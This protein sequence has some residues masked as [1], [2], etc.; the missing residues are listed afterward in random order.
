MS[1]LIKGELL[2]LYVYDGAA[3][4]PIA[5]LT[6]NS[7]SQTRAVIEAQTKCEPGVT[8]KSSGAMAYS[9]ACEGLYIDTT[10]ATGEQTKASHDY[11]KEAFMDTGVNFTWKMD[12]GLA[13]NPAYFGTALL[14]A[15]D[16]TLPSGDEF[17]NFTGTLDGSGAIVLVDPELP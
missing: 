15:L 12:T 5:C 13:D 6:S 16:L 7:L 4:R 11:L 2:I 10:S 8:E 1:N 14:T 17:A 3:Y 9:L